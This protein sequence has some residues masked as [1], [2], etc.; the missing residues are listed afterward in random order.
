MEKLNDIYNFIAV[1]K[2]SFIIAFGWFLHKGFPALQTYCE[3]RDGGTIPNLFS[4]AFGKPKPISQ[5]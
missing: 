3:S 4:K 2:V 5:S 1:N